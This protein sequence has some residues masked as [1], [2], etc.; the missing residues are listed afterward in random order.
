MNQRIRINVLGTLLLVLSTQSLQAQSVCLP[1]PRLLTTM[2]MGGQVGTT[3]EVT[4]TGENFEDAE[5]LSF[6]HPGIK[7]IPKLDDKGLP[8]PNQF[9]VTI[10]PD[11]PTGIYDARVMTRL[12][13]SSSRAFNVGMLPEVM[14]KK[15][16]TT[17][18]TAMPLQLNTICNATMTPKAI[19]FYSFEAKR[20]QRIVID[21]AAKGIDSKLNA[22]LIVADASGSDLLVERRGGALDFIA[23][24]DG[25]YVIKAHDLTFNG[26]GHYFYRLALIAA[27]KDAVIARLPSIEDVN[28]F[29]WPPSGLSEM[30]LATEV[31]PNNQHSEAQKISLPCDLNGSFFPAADVDTFEF[32]AKK[33]E[34]WWV[35]VASERIGRPT[36]PSI[37]VQHVSGSG[38]DEK[39]TD[40]AELTD[41]GSPVKVSSNGYSYDGPP[42]NAGSSDILG[43]LEIKQ[44]GVHRLQILDLFGGTRNDP[45]NVYRLIIRKA[46]PD[47]ALVSWAL[48]MNLRNGDRN[49]LSK[50]IAL[51]GGSTMPIEVV[52]VRRD[53]FSGPIE[54]SMKNLPEGVTATGMT[55]PAG[56]T[57]GIM[58][59]TADQNT[60]RGLTNAE[61]WGTAKIGDNVVTRPV[62]MASMSWPVPNAWS[63]IPSP[64]LMADIPVSV[65]GSEL[66]PVTIVAAE[67]KIFE[68]K[69]G[70]QLTIPLKHIRRSE[71]SGT[72]M[73]L[74]TWGPGFEKNA[75]FD[76]PLDA[77]ASETTIDLAKLKPEPG[78]YQI[79]F[80]G[81]AV[82]KYRY[83]PEA[84][85][86]AEITLKQAQETAAAL[87][88]EVK[89]LTASL[90][91]VSDEQ[92]AEV[93][94]AVEAVTAKQKT[95][96]AAVKAAEQQ[97]KTATAAAT[98][99]D[100]V[101]IVVSTPLTIRVLS[102]EETAKK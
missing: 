59:I 3:V 78:E 54:L 85:S 74:N 4:I 40:V 32:T 91:M 34:I 9:L 88:E 69:V 68:A 26:G 89:M 66:A 65:C 94:A 93:K 87:A 16:N 97:L 14:Q 95:A 25:T 48:H 70:E 30:A 29:S 84:V 83:N 79:A 44:D 100:I 2:P 47:F 75:A 58:L 39:L 1:A 7:A 63:D 67:D 41:I 80:Y 62:R 64:R 99:K 46:E 23:P 101:D 52:V 77:D 86:I 42:Y 49:A 20:D 55:I 18:E 98:P 33:G 11:C 22:V 71:F 92:Q 27:E 8:V 31:E 28:S 72:K 73:S 19:D 81:S 21:C 61:F 96:D 10:A 90:E 17:L 24:E 53:G 36:D 102:A 6:S 13:I 50:P 82:A 12:G 37:V 76:L 57:Q 15:P 60:P 43:K 51:R 35:E 38:V 45:A 5:E 56:A